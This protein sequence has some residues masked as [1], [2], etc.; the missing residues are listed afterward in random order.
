L[1]EP[2]V[3][4]AFF[5]ASG[6]CAFLT[7]CGGVAPTSSNVVLRLEVLE[8]N[9]Y[10]ADVRLVYANYSTETFYMNQA[11]MEACFAGNQC[12]SISV[13]TYSDPLYPGEVRSATETLYLVD[14]IYGRLESLELTVEGYFPSGKHITL[15]SGKTYL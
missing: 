1:L 2:K 6:C 4:F 8:R 14:P 11:S 12:F 10:S 7:G 3:S 9:A 15:S 5:G 13:P